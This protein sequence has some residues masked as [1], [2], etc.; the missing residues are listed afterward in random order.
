MSK[1]W[2]A[3]MRNPGASGVKLTFTVQEFPAVIVPVQVLPLLRVKSRLGAPWVT[4]VG[5]APNV[6]SPC[7]RYN[8]G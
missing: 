7:W 3:P 4:T 1:S 5:F 8:S 2:T 6:V